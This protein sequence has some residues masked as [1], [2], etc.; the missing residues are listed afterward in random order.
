MSHNATGLDSG[1]PKV[2]DLLS[3][4]MICYQQSCRSKAGSVDG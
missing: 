1:L 4:R 2:A 3:S